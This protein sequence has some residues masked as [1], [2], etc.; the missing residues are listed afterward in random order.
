MHWTLAVCRGFFVFDFSKTLDFSG[1]L[2]ILPF[3]KKAKSLKN[4][5]YKLKQ[6][7]IPTKN[8]TFLS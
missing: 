1:F 4:L 2:A 8:L 6:N 3:G 5:K 7:I